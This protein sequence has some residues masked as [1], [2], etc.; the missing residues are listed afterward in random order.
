MMMM[1]IFNQTLI[2]ELMQVFFRQNKYTLEMKH[3]LHE[4]RFSR[5]FLQM[6][7]KRKKTQKK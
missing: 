1:T 5:L 3:I 2:D 6:K 4:L 7:E